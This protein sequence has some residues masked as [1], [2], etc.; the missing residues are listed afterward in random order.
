MFILEQKYGNDGY[1]FWF[2]LLE[3][4]GNSE[5][6]YIDLNDQT[7]WEFLTSKTRV[8]DET[9][10]EILNLLAKLDAIDKELW[11]SRIVWSQNFVDRIKDAY[12][13]RLSEMPNKPDFLRK[14]PANQSESDAGNP[15]TKVKESKVKETKEKKGADAFVCPEWIPLETWKAYLELRKKK[16]AADTFYALELIVSELRKI[17]EIHNHDPVEVL[18]KS[19]KSGWIDVYPLKE[20]GGNGSGTSNFGGGSSKTDGKAQNIPGDREQYPV[21]AEF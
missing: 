10:E 14:K 6:H 16:K 13:N 4:L 19:I 2:K 7:E 21:D 17:K 5:G 12:R 15:Q 3:M 18:N 11:D 8:S 20:K 9:S 1:A